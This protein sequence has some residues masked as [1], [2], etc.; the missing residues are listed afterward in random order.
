MDIITLAM[1][2]AY[3]DKKSVVVDFDKIGLTD[4]ILYLLNSGGGDLL[5]QNMTGGEAVSEAMCRA[6]PENACVAKLTVPGMGAMVVNPVYT[7][8]DEYG[9]KVAHFDSYTENS[10][11][12]NKF[13]VRLYRNMTN[14]NYKH[15]MVRVGFYT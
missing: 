11:E 14:A 15:G 12:L 2:K 8:F 5:L 4:A 3:T 13:Y 9:F 7:L 1:A 6:I 10:T